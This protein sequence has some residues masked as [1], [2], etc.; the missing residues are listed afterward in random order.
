MSMPPILLKTLL[1]V[2]EKNLTEEKVQNLF[3][4]IADHYPIA[5]GRGKNVIIL[6]RRADTTMAS[7]ATVDGAEIVALHEQ[8]PLVETLKKAISQL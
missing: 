7:V 4:T 6:S 8:Q 2:V 5:E 3:N 1:P